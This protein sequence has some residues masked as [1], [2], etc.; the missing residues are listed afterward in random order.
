MGTQPYDPMY[1][2]NRGYP[3]GPQSNQGWGLALAGL[4]LGITALGLFWIPVIS[5]LALLIAV[6]GLGLAI[7][8]LVTAVRNRSSA[9][10]L[11]IAAVI[12]SGIACLMCLFSTF[13][14]SALFS[15]LGDDRRSPAPAVTLS[16]PAATEGT[17]LPSPVSPPGSPTGTGIS[18]PATSSSSPSGPAASATP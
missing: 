17:T 7:G 12:V 11:S 3:G 14:W 1:N 8:G 10:G 16:S 9:K 4:I 6:V 5:F 15:S 13:L 18:S 2:Y